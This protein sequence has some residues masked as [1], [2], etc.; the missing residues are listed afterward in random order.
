METTKNKRKRPFDGKER[1]INIPYYGSNE[2]VLK[3]EFGKYFIPEYGTVWVNNLGTKVIGK[4]GKVLAVYRN[5]NGYLEIRSGTTLGTG[6]SRTWWSFSIHRLV[7]LAFIPNPYNLPEIN[8]KDGNKFNNC[9]ENLEWCTGKENIE[10]A[11][12]NNLR[13][14]FKGSK[15]GRSKLN[16]SQVRDIKIMLRDTKI[17]HKK[18]AEAYGVSKET[19]DDISRGK[20]WKHVVI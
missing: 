5:E 7:S 19:I 8:H 9:I 13:G 2:L 11:V 3:E 17:T 18:I 10:H 6:D 15:N 16:E 1:I 20:N 12:K 4:S 14:D